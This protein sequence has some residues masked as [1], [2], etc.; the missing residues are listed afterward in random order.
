MQ[1]PVG[2]PGRRGRGMGGSTV[3][4]PDGANRITEE[5]KKVWLDE[6]EE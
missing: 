6:G 4:I 1:T 2:L 3:G 5:L